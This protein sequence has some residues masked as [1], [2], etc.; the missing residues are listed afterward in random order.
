MSYWAIKHLPTGKFMP[1]LPQRRGF[2]HNEPEDVDLFPP[3]L[4][5][6]Q[7][8]AKVAL[9]WWLKGRT[10]VSRSGGGGAP[11]DDYDY[12]EDW[13]TEPVPERRA[14]DMAV[15]ALR[16][17]ELEGPPVEQ[18]VADAMRWR[19]LMETGRVRVI[20]CEDDR[21]REGS[22]R[23]NLVFTIEFGRGL[24]DIYDRIDAHDLLMEFSEALLMEN[25]G[26][27]GSINHET[28]T[29]GTLQSE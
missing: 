25:F 11:W 7:S 26:S 16:F 18:A 17:T 13:H 29:G 15:V 10:S 14:E 8:S 1:S 28:G 2:T 12:D 21:P 6:S 24:A 3:R 20:D 19:A 27:V 22:P 23:Q 9:A 4:F 5:T